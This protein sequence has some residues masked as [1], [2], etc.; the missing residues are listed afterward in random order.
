MAKSIIL[1]NP[2]FKKD[3]PINEPFI[4][5][6]EFFCDTIQGENFVGW[7]SAFLRVQNCTQSCVWCDTK[8]VWRFGNPYTFT[9]LFEMMQEVDLIRKFQSGQHLVLT[10]GSPVMAQD[11][12]I[13]FLNAFIGRYGFKPFIEIENECTRMPS[14]ELVD[15][16]DLWNNS[17]QLASSGNPDSIR[18]RPEILKKVSSLHNTWFKFVVFRE[19]DWE[20]IYNDFLYPGLIKKWQ[21]VLMPLG[22]TRA[23]LINNREKVIDIAIRENVRYASREHIVVWDKKTGI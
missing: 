7:P 5:V 23:E 1:G 15:L 16:V 21:I 6:A 19:E 4:D 14:D 9:E 17:P 3:V 8:E 18:Y 12:L 20:E 2:D 11:K 10:G 13:P 22:A